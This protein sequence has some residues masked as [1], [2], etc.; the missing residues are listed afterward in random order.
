MFKGVAC[1]LTASLLFGFLYYFSTSLEPL[2]GQSIFAYRIVFS[3]PLMWIIFFLFKQKPYLIAY[4]QR[5]QKQ[6]WLILVLLITA[7]ISGFEMWL[8]L[9]AP[10]NNEA[11][12]VSV[13]YLILPLV[14][15][16]FGKIFFKE[17]ITPFKSL[18]IIF[19]GLAVLVD[20]IS[21]SGGS[22]TSGAVCA[23][24]IYFALRRRFNITDLASLLIEFTLMLPVCF[25][26]IY[27]T[28]LSVVQQNNPN[29]I[30]RLI[31]LGII[32][33]V[34]FTVYILAS[35]LLPMNM[36]G[37]LSYM[38]PILLLCSA[39]ILG[40]KITS[41]DYPLFIGLVLAIVCVIIDGVLEHH[42]S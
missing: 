27:Q 33:G 21:K 25:Y 23:Y 9:W 1:S 32:S 10:H 14:L 20:I 13:G 30:W 16:L 24:A 41:Q 15:V 26:F 11:I 8:F 7:T 12:N 17:K 42:H 3:M 39:V 28:D 34:A 37:L 35:N 22:W 36:L 4:K 40:E 19:A 5:L 18:A 2:S 38:E 6:P 29:I 31:F